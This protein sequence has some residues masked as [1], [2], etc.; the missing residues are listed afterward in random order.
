MQ[1]SECASGSSVEL[2]EDDVDG[3]SLNGRQPSELIMKELR[4]WLLCRGIENKKLKT[5]AELLTRQ[6]YL[7]TFDYFMYSDQNIYILRIIIPHTDN[8]R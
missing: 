6:V 4:F 2:T 7:F 1:T 5:R 3:A 8:S